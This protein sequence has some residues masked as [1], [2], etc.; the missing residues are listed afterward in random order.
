MPNWEIKRT[1]AFLKDIKKHR[2]N[3]EL[4]LEL[5]KRI[6]RLLEDPIAIG[7]NLAGNLHGHK[8]TRLA[9]NFRLI[10]SIDEI[11]KVVYLVT[12]DHR[13]DVY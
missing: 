10:F 11:N 9:K 4:L 13:K 7:G 2:T 3:H 6:Q 8:S 12:I 1:D 5:D